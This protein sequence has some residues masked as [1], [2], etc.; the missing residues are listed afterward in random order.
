MT[1]IM[2][3]FLVR[4]LIRCNI[5]EMRITNV[6]SFFDCV[7][8]TTYTWY[9]GAGEMNRRDAFYA[10]FEDEYYIQIHTSGVAE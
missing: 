5:N 6:V 3:D 7:T 10:R 4:R 9:I 2:N 8:G 1:L